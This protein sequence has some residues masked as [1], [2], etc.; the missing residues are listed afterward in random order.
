MTEAK[1]QGA[2][3][4]CPGCGAPVACGVAAGE[5]DCWCFH[6]PPSGKVPDG[7]GH[8][9]CPACLEKFRNGAQGLEGA[10]WPEKA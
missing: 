4:P 1:Q 3:H 5:K 7:G 10:A 9:Y 6:L 8:C 2:L